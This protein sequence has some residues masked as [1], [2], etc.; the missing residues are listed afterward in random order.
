MQ[1][2]SAML[3]ALINACIISTGAAAPGDIVGT[4]EGTISSKITNVDGSKSRQKAS[5]KIEIAIDDR[6]TVTINGVVQDTAAGGY[7]PG[8]GV[9]IFGN[10]STNPT[11]ANLA[12]IQITNGTLKGTASGYSIFEDPGPP[13]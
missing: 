10:T 8:G 11:V 1:I 13:S 5:L 9:I 4:Y 7:G 6:T 3:L 12:S 2:K